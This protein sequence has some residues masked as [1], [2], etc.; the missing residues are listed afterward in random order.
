M[1]VPRIYLNKPL[2]YQ[3]Q[4]ELDKETAHRL[5]TVLR[6]TKEQ[7]I[8]LFNGDGHEYL[9]E[10][11]LLKKERIHVKIKEVNERN[12]ESSL[13]LHLGQVIS[14]GDKMDFV[15]Q[16]A[17][18][19]GIT[20]I[21]PLFSERCVVHL[22]QERLEKKIEHWQ[23]ICIH[24]AEQC[25]RTQL[26][27]LE[28][29]MALKDWVHARTEKTRLML[30]LSASTG[31]SKI[32]FSDDISLMIGPEG[33]L[34]LDEIDYAVQYGFTAIKLGPRVLRTETATIVA[35]SAIQLLAGDLN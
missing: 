5:T 24:A 23:R 10:I 20:R 29:P 17:T 13:K 8:I 34:S 7:P 4:V 22:N 32:E 26:P 9:S 3:A 27:M 12:L 16:K 18:E 15:I 2:H 21:T 19:L 6:I 11:I 35:V 30:A 14:K 1:R 25:G 31:L 33:G 28:K